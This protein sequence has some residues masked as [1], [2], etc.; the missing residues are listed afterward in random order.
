MKKLALLVVKIALPALIIGW[1][2]RGIDETQWRE[3][4]ETDKDWGLLVAS[5]A[6]A[7]LAVAVTFVRWF[8]LVRALGIPFRLRDSFRLGSLGYLFNFVS[9]G[10]VGG[11]LFKAFFIAREQPGR[12]AEAVAT[13]VVDRMIGLYALLIL[14]SLA[15]GVG[16]SQLP[17]SP[18]V[19]TIGRL[20]LM[21]TAAGAIGI[22]LVLIPGFTRGILSRFL[23]RLPLVGRLIPQLISAVRIYRNKRRVLSEALAMSLVSHSLFVVAIHL[24]AAAILPR[25]ADSPPTLAEHFV[26]VPLSMVA[27]ALPLMPAGL[28]ALEFSMDFLYQEFAAR[29]DQQ[30]AARK[31]M[32]T[33][34]SLVF[35]MVTICVAVV[36]VIVY[37]TSR[38]EVGQVMDDAERSP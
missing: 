20:T 32:G 17:S 37:W 27:G 15:I 38:R 4:K 7:N 19:R 10:A 28:G 24:D 33:I 26:I 9:V 25:T 14:T 12:R 31:G 22:M 1:L 6:I 8:L 21:G 11:D 35:R 36:G 29:Q 23:A 18:T 30:V 16:G 5:F 3:L 2:L 13:V 34:V